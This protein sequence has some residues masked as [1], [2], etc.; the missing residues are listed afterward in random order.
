MK[1]SLE[2]KTSGVIVANTYRNL[3]DYVLPMITSE[4]WEALG[5]DDGWKTLFPEFNKQDLIATAVNGSKIYFRSCDREGDLR[6]PNLGWFYIDEAAKVTENTWKIMQGRI[7]KPPEMGWITTTPKG[8]NW[9]WEEFAKQKRNNYE[10]W[11]GSTDENVH[12]ST[13]YVDSLKEAYGTKTSWFRQEFC[14]E[15]TAW[16]GLVYPQINVE[17]HHLDA[18]TDGGYKYALAGC[19]WG[20]ADPSVLLVGLVGMDGRIHIVEEYYKTRQSVENIA[21]AADKLREK[22]NVRTFWCDPSRPDAVAALRARGLDS[23]KAKNE[24][25]AGI[26]SVTQLIEKDLFRADFNACPELIREFET[27]HYG[28]DDLGKVLKDRPVDKDNHCLDALRYLVYSNS[29]AGHASSRR[30]AR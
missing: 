23:R 24:I 10:W 30:G 15:F 11:T 29:R 12:L 14:G 28:E 9:I 17:S 13:G 19:D 16:E 21:D 25:D 27:Y 26:A 20:F 8:R 22:W 7:R 1:R 5:V 6:G 4:L 2:Q 18:P 3:K